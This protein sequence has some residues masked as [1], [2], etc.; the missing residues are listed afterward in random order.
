MCLLIFVSVKNWVK[1]KL[2]TGLS[3]EWLMFYPKQCIRRV[4]ICRCLPWCVLSKNR[5]ASFCGCRTN[6]LRDY[7]WRWAAA[8][9]SVLNTTILRS[10]IHMASV[11]IIAN[12]PLHPMGESSSRTHLRT[13]DDESTY[14]CIYVT[15]FVCSR[16]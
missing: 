1:L 10:P 11:V 12:P 16:I 15:S 4:F 9:T 8:S 3:W 6:W 13:D 14:A 2:K 5:T 7:T